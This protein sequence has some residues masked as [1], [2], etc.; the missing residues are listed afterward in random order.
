METS[1]DRIVD[2]FQTLTPAGVDAL[3]AIARF[4]AELAKIPNVLQS[5]APEVNL[6]DI[7]LVGTVIAV[8]KLA[9]LSKE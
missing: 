8:P 4:K 3:D 7:N 2:A 1:V 5:P 6:L 9:L